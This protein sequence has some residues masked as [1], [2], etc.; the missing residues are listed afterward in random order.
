V[1]P[2]RRGPLFHYNRS[3]PL[4]GSFSLNA[5]LFFNK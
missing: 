4:R 5:N 3:A 1:V 2:N